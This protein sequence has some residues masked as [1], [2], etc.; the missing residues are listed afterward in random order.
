M[1]GGLSPPDVNTRWGL[2]NFGLSYALL[3]AVGALPLR[4]VAD[5]VVAGVVF[6]LSALFIARS[7]RKLRKLAATT[8]LDGPEL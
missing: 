2:F 5:A 7:I 4:H 8:K 6:V 3:S 1:S